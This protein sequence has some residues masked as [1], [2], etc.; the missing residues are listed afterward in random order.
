[1][2]LR[3]EVPISLA[4]LEAAQD[5]A[6][7]W[8]E[9][10]GV[11]PALV[12]RLRLVVEE[13]VANLVEHAAWPGLPQGEAPPPARLEA[14]FESGRLRLVLFDAARPFDPITAPEAAAPSLDDDRVGGL[15][16]ALV[17]RMSRDLA[18]A[19]GQ[20]G[21]NRTSLFISETH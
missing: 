8:A 5:A 15:G 20:D 12:L 18:Y 4:G 7:A 3:L 6:E 19:P 2:T 13:L 17:R 1:M 10:Q 9:G 14:G 16:L 11:P 21:W